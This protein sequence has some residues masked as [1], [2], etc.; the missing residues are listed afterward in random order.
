MESRLSAFM[1]NGDPRTAALNNSA[2]H[3]FEEGFNPSPFNIS[4]HWIS[5]YRGQGFSMGSIHQ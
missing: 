1:D 3:S 5:K 4:Q 2:P